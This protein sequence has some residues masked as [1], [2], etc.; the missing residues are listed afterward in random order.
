MVSVRNTPAEPGWRTLQSHSV[1]ANLNGSYSSP[2]NSLYDSFLGGDPFAYYF[3]V[4]I[5][6]ASMLPS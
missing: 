1:G 5:R 4:L 6:N 3:C 2:Y